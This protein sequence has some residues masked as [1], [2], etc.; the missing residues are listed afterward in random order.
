MSVTVSFDKD[1]G[2]V[3]EVEEF[4]DKPKKTNG[5]SFDFPA[6]FGEMWFLTTGPMV[7][8]PKFFTDFSK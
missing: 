8:I 1:V 2:E 5:T 3:D 4:V 7:T 6:I